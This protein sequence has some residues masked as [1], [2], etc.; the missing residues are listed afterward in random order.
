MM[1]AQPLTSD[2]QDELRAL[3]EFMELLGVTEFTEEQWTRWQ[4]LNQKIRDFY[5]EDQ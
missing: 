4:E 5:K 3:N 1:T 2:E